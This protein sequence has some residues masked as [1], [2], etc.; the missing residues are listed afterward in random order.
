MSAA[1]KFTPGPWMVGEI[2]WAH[3]I[4]G[5][6]IS[7]PYDG[8]EGGRIAKCFGNCLVTTDAE[9]IANARLIAAAPKLHSEL[10]K[11]GRR[12]ETCIDLIGRTWP[13]V[14]AKMSIQ[15]ADIRA[16]LAKVSA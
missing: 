9:V 5:V 6:F 13:Y 3:G 8:R 4:T 7:Q 2:E 16:A 12:L 14:A 15:L 11:A 10:T 1:P